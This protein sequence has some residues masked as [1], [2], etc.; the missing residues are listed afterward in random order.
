MGFSLSITVSGCT[1]VHGSSFCEAVLQAV[2]WRRPAQSGVFPL[3]HH[4]PCSTHSLAQAKAGEAAAA[5]AAADP[6]FAAKQEADTRS[7]YVG[8]VDYG[9]HLY[10]VFCVQCVL[11]VYAG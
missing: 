6:E 5:G 8:N 9:A 7:V 3:P 2:P 10:Y 4:R 1:G 11:R